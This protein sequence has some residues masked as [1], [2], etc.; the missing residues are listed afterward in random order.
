MNWA[1]ILWLV[2]FVGFLLAEGLS[3]M[4]ISLWF[5]AGALA[6]LLVNLLGG[7]LWLQVLVFVVTSVVL[8]ISLRP[9]AKKYFTPRIARTN[10]DA[11]L[12]QEGVV[13]E[14]IDN[15]CAR[16]RVKIAAMEW[17]ARST[18]GQSIPAGTL[19]KVDKIEGVKA[20]VSP[21]KVEAEV[22]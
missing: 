4:V 19:V 11:V 8:L 15:V 10:V 22:H 2:L 7:E 20:F 14:E 1:S 13:I 9:L 18:T 3:V 5:A 16:G 12:D 6:A 21:V 17:S